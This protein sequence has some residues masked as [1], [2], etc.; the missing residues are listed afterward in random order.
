MLIK[1]IAAFHVKVNN[2]YG[3]LFFENLRNRCKI[4]HSTLIRNLK[5]EMVKEVLDEIKNVFRSK[6]ESSAESRSL[7]SML[8][9][10]V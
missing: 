10:Y 1:L 7:D 8:H 9:G 2:F 5:F 6:S 4:Q 3:F